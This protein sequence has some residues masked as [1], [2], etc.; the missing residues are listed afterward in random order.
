M[1]TDAWRGGGRLAKVRKRRT[2]EE[3]K[4]VREKTVA[5]WRAETS[6]TCK[7]C[8]QGRERREGRILGRGTC[9]AK[10]RFEKL[11]FRKSSRRI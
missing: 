8:K 6:K 10:L 3:V 9:A 11:R 1:R 4:R 2:E 5:L 7:V